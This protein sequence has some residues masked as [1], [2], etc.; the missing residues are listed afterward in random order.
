MEAATS[1]M[2][3]HVCDMPVAAAL[4]WMSGVARVKVT[5]SVTLE[6]FVLPDGADAESPT[7]KRRK[8]DGNNTH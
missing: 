3:P 6:L 1:C 8:M 7:H 5:G 4:N 2:I